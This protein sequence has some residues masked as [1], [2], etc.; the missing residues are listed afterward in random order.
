MRL[1]LQGAHVVQ[2]I[3]QGEQQRAA[4]LQHGP[5]RS[6][7]TVGQVI[8]S[9]TALNHVVGPLDLAGVLAFLVFFASDNA[10][11]LNGSYTQEE[12]LRLRLCC[13]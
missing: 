7:P 13:P 3:P 10:I 6:A 9:D 1:A 4:D 12:M 2:A 11:F 8:D 5:S